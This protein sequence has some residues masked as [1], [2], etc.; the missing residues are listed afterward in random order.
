MKND[1]ASKTRPNIKAK[2]KRG[3]KTKESVLDS[4]VDLFFDHGFSNTST[5]EL[6]RKAGMSSSAIYNHFTDKHQIL[7]TIID[8]AGEKVLLI[9]RELIAQYGEPEECLKQMIACLIRLFETDMKKEI[10]IFMDELNQL[11]PDL[12]KICNAKHRKIFDLYKKKIDEI[13]STGR[14]NPIDGTVATFG[15]MGAMIWV[16]RWYKDDGVLDADDISKELW[17]L[18]SGGLMASK[19]AGRSS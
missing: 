12:K 5:R 8:R 11:P 16:Y 1:R 7:F 17:K 10:A 14:M 18:I 19:T 3:E 9:L 6:V 2:Y 13:R 4:A 15:I